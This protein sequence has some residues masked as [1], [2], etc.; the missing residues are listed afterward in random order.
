MATTAI[1]QVYNYVADSQFT[2]AEGRARLLLQTSGGIASHPRLFE[3]WISHGRPGAAALLTLGRIARTRF[4]TPPAMVARIVAAA[5]PI[6]TADGE[7]VRFEV[8]SPCNGVYARLDLGPS[9]LDGAFFAV[10]TTNVDFGPHIRELL[11]RVKDDGRIFLS[12]GPD[13]IAIATSGG[14][15]VERRVRLP[16]RWIKGLAEVQVA[17]SRMELD[18]ELDRGEA[19]S[20]LRSLPTVPSRGSI[21]LQRIADGLRISRSPEGTEVGGIERLRVLRDLASMATRLRIYR[22]TSGDP[23]TAWVLDLPGM[24]VH[25]VLSPDRARGFSGEGEVL[26][27]L[28]THGDGAKQSAVGRLGYDLHEQRFFAR[29]LPFDLAKVEA[30]QPRLRAARRLVADRA[31]RFLANGEAVVRSSEVEHRVRWAEDGPH[32]TCPWFARYAGRRGPCKHV[33]AAELTRA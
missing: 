17:Q 32:C 22:A 18:M 27:Q 30:E 25:A 3:G 16:V 1:E 20:F 14:E 12:M 6:A 10:G 26:G 21:Y 2:V 29:E 8:F 23:A 24:R 15:A 33:L 5:D 31:V 11:A 28:A 7:N 9:A 19:V 4:Y 13:D